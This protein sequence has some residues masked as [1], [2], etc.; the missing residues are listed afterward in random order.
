[1]SGRGGG[2]TIFARSQGADAEA[3]LRI[4]ARGGGG[5]LRLGGDGGHE[6]A[7][8]DDPA[9]GNGAFDAGSRFSSV[10]A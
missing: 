3:P 1:M 7:G 9:F 6:R 5:V 2:H 4:A 8:D 10:G